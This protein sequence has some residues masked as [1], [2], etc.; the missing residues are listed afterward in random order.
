MAAVITV[1]LVAGSSCLSISSSEPEEATPSANVIPFHVGQSVREV[2]ALVPDGARMTK[3]RISATYRLRWRLM[4]EVGELEKATIVFGKDDM[5]RMAAVGVQAESTGKLEVIPSAFLI[6]GL[7][8]GAS[9]E[10]V[11][12]ATRDLGLVLQPANGDFEV[13]FP[14]SPLADREETLGAVIGD[15]AYYFH[16]LEGQ[17][18]GVG[19]SL[20]Q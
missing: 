17:L 12:S 13:F 7:H 15:V 4:I 2:L 5:V 6:K 10:E 1:I 16:F 3:R 20:N 8:W 19:T 9:R 11:T 14:A 18:V